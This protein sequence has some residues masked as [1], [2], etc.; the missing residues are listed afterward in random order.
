M[1]QTGNLQLRSQHPV[2]TTGGDASTFTRV[3]FPTP[4]PAGSDVIVH[5]TTQTFDAPDTP[6]IRL[7]EV[8]ETGFLIRFNEL[9][10]AGTKS[11]GLHGLETVG[12][13]AYTV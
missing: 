9:F 7:H 12:W 5:A 8:S 11:N 2:A 1:I 3:E 6:G 4:F 10:G 13:T